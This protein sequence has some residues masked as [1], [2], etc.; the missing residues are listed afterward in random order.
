MSKKDW[1]IIRLLL[2]TK[3]SNRA[4]ALLADPMM[5]I[6][7]KQNSP[8][9]GHLPSFHT[10]L[11]WNPLHICRSQGSLCRPA[12]TLTRPAT[13]VTVGYS[14]MHWDFFQ[15]TPGWAEVG[16]TAETTLV[17]K[18]GAVLPGSWTEIRRKPEEHRSAD[19]SS[20]KE[21]FIARHHC[22]S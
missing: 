14:Q 16:L 11:H 21:H 13:S 8:A 7:N 2:N 4:R 10:V 12:D 20:Q 6:L 18:G 19:F 1:L 22:S 9:R 15:H 3:D 17:I 5:L